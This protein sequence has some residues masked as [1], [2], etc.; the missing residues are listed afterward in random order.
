MLRQAIVPRE[1]VHFRAISSR[2][3]SAPIRSTKAQR[4]PGDSKRSDAKRP[5]AEA[6]PVQ[7]GDI[8]VKD[9]D[10]ST[11]LAVE[12]IISSYC[13]AR[14]VSIGSINWPKGRCEVTVTK[15]TTVDEPQADERSSSGISSEDLHDIHRAV[16]RK[17]EEDPA[18]A[19]VLQ[20]TEV[21]TRTPRTTN[22]L[23]QRM[24]AF[25]Y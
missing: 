1:M 22:Y 8:E 21:R 10:D 7:T 5:S 17:I 2:G 3:N 11:K 9:A 24:C 18:L 15:A 16:Y 20:S 25:R 19:R 13:S 14:Q 4:R 23:F 12:A 6:T